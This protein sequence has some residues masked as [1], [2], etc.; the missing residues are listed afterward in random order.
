M[1]HTQRPPPASIDV[2]HHRLSHMNQH[3]LQ[4]LHR[5]GRI[6]IQGKKL[7][8]PCDFCFAAKKTN[9]QGKGPTPR[10]TYPGMR[11]HVDIFGG[12][13]TLGKESDDEA[14]PANGKYK[15]AMIVTD[16]AT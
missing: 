11:L 14:P 15:Y 1:A 4:Y 13:K 5:I 7:L 9:Q 16:D 8:T 2:W 3:D 10:A 6:N 12:G